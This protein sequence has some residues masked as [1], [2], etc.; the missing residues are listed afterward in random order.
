MDI[1]S[2][3]ISKT[4]EEEAPNSKEKNNYEVVIKNHNNYIKSGYLVVVN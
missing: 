2:M 4:V 3:H 1:G